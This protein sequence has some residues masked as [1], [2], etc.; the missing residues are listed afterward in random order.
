M[1]DKNSVHVIGLHDVTATVDKTPRCK[2][3]KSAEAEKLF[4][5]HPNNVVLNFKNMLKVMNFSEYW[6]SRYWIL[7]PR[8]RENPPFQPTKWARRTPAK[9]ILLLFKRVRT[10]VVATYVEH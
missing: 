7:N 3:W 6:T 1:I 10:P 9:T 8:D 5:L 2:I 4:N